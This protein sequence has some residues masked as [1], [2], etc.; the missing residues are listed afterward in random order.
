[1]LWGC[2]PLWAHFCGGK[3][4]QQLLGATYGAF[5]FWWCFFAGAGWSFN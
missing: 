5:I 2:N 4:I 3:P 1:M